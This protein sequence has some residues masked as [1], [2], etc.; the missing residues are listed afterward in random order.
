MRR[1]KPEESCESRRAGRVVREGNIGVASHLQHRLR[2]GGQ[3]KKRAEIPFS[4][5]LTP[6]LYFI[7]KGGKARAK[8]LSKSRRSAIAQQAARA[9]ERKTGQ[10]RY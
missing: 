5:E 1:R 6:D 10:V 2:S 9:R 4:S 3:R 8:K 7:P